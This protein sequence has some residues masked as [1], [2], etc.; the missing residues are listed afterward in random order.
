MIGHN[1]R[2]GEHNLLC[3]Q[4]GIAGSCSTG[5]FVIMAGQVGIGDHLEIGSQVIIAAQSGV[6]HN[7]ASGQRVLGSPAIGAKQQ[8][9]ILACQHKLPEMRRQLNELERVVS[10]STI[11]GQERRINRAA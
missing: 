9:Q 11:A 4:V 10:Q 1:C 7:I 5:D 6:M 2:I 3:S 8:M